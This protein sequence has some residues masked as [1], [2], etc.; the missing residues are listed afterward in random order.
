[1]NAN[2]TALN[3]TDRTGYRYFNDGEPGQAHALAH[4]LL[5]EGREAEGLSLLGAW[6]AE[7]DGA[8]SEWVHL[9]WHLAVFEIAA[10]RLEQAHQR[11]RERILPALPAGEALTDAPSLLWRLWLA[12]GDALELE[13]EAVRQAALAHLGQNS[14]LYVE[15]HNL[16]ALAGARDIP[17]IDRWLDAKYADADTSKA[18]LLLQM[19]WALRTFANRD[20]EPAATLLQSVKRVSRLGGS[21]AQNLLFECIRAEAARQGASSAASAA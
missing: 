7:H 5:D 21:G 2:S 17:A 8:G 1:M 14:D 6:L 16:L 10:G 3:A 9:H 18:C 20:Y 15:L 19:A 12:G 13:W 11:F 4:E